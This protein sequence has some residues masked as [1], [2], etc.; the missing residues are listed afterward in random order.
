VLGQGITGGVTPFAFGYSLFARS[1]ASNRPLSYT[2]L[3]L[4]AAEILVI[5]AFII[6]AVIQA[7]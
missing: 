7:I 2:A 6:G 4:C 1:R 3:V 5:T